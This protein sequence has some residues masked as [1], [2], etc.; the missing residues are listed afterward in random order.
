VS[1]KGS[2]RENGVA[3]WCSREE[4]DS[5]DRLVSVLEEGKGKKGMSVQ[6]GKL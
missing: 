2:S 5:T 1:N 4:K 6:E 3:Y